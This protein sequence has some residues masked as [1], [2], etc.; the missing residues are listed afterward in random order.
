MRSH[1]SIFNVIVGKISATTGREQFSTKIHS[2]TY[3]T[4]VIL[5]YLE[6][7]IQVFMT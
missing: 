2:I 1:R 5:K 7:E 4:P 3:I 6:S